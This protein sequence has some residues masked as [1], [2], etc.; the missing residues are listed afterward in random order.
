MPKFQPTSDAKHV[1]LYDT[2]TKKH[3]SFD[4]DDD[5]SNKPPVVSTPSTSEK[6]PKKRPQSDQANDNNKKR[7]RPDK[8][9][10]TPRPYIIKP[11]YTKKEKTPLTAAQ[12]QA[13][14]LAK[15]DAKRQKMKERR[16]TKKFANATNDDSTKVDSSIRLLQ[17][18]PDK[19]KGKVTI[20][21]LR[22]FI[23]YCLTEGAPP[24]FARIARSSCVDRMVVIYVNGLDMTT[25]GAPL[26]REEVPPLVDLEQV[27]R[28]TAIGKANMPFL[29]SQ[30]SHM[31]VT[32]MES[33]N[34]EKSMHPLSD[35]LQCQ[36]SWSRREKQYQELKEK[37]ENSD[38]DKSELYILSPKELA[39]GGY[40]VPPFLDPTVTLPS[41]WK[42]TKPASEP[43]KKKRLIAVDCEMVLTKSGSSLARVS[44]IDED[45]EV[46]LDEYVLPDE[47]ILDYLTEYSGI[48]KKIMDETTCSLRRA[49]KHI[50]K[51]IDH[52]VILVG[53]SL[54]S[55]LKA[56]KLAHPY[57]VD[58]AILYDSRRGPPFRPRLRTLAKNFLKRNI[59]QNDA[60]RAK[61]GHNSAEDA[62]ATM[63][64]FKLK[65]EKGF[66][67]GRKKESLELVF[68]RLAEFT[69]PKR[70][71]IMETNVTGQQTFQS[72]L[73]SRYARHT[74]DEALAADLVEK[75]STDENFVLA[76]FEAL[77]NY[78]DEEGDG[79]PPTVISNLSADKDLA[80]RLTKLD[81]CLKT[82]YEGVP[83][84]TVLLLMGGVGNVYQYRR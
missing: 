79:A 37:L 14:G 21:D 47:P 43:A 9:K 52:N 48:T 11:E 44:L 33:T 25:F 36:V 6:Q 58:T 26:S 41:D 73:G 22:N 30:T 76:Q 80:K 66:A 3:I 15:R 38:I 45:G 23:L 83:K 78:D 12:Q 18:T 65:I 17:M 70:G 63:D 40:P 31:L 13:R 77:Q 28:T 5:D 57:C 50:R 82:I 72:T 62:R 39:A 61:L 71:I 49:Q 68:D 19:V 56:L 75:V 32:R 51:L 60:Q 55:D 29:M 46:L 24:K 4:D 67:F 34:T 64:L 10:S 74:T 84:N 69:P 53:H 1:K 27:D 59:Q 35:L 81:V 7:S 42:E 8:Q 54:D 16:R 2:S 20:P